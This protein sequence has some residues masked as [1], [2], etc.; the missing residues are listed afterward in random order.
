MVVVYTLIAVSVS[1]GLGVVVLP[2]ALKLYSEFPDQQVSLQILVS[3]GIAIVIAWIFPIIAILTTLSRRVVVEGNLVF[4]KKKSKL[5]IGKWEIEKLIDFSKIGKITERQKAVFTGKVTVVYYWLIFESKD[6]SKEE[7]LLNGWDNGA[8]RNLF[9][10]LRGKFPE[11]KFDTFV[12]R[13][14]PEKLSGLD[15]FL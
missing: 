9:Y 4:F 3:I 10:Y 14:S 7:L 2:K 13:D 15:K 12:L 11:I 8:I 6:G 1:L 5:G